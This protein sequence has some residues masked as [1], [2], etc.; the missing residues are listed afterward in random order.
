LKSH[1]GLENVIDEDEGPNQFEEEIIDTA[2][3]LYYG[4]GIH[5]NK[6][7]KF[8]SA[9]INDI[10]DD[11]R[12]LSQRGRLY[13]EAYECQNKNREYN[14]LILIGLYNLF[15]V[16]CQSY[17]EWFFPLFVETMEIEQLTEIGQHHTAVIRAGSLFEHYLRD[18]S[19]LPNSDRST[20]WYANRAEDANMIS[21][22]DRK[23]IHFVVELR[24]DA[25]HQTWM[26]TKYDYGVFSLGGIVA[27]KLSGDL[28]IQEASK[29]D[30][31]VLDRDPNK[32]SNSK[33]F[34]KII[35]QDFGWVYDEGI[36]KWRAPEQRSGL[37]RWMDWKDN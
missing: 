24:N 17:D 33:D 1:F 37:E 10:S 2:R 21:K 34:I 14:G 29:V 3:A 6:Y 30:E 12:E 19:E 23:L 7:E 25:G 18:H 16:V 32:E 15:E 35:E 26:R 5:S 36:K 11:K 8:R 31:S 27:T 22:E 28:M 9:A 4:F 13:W 20:A